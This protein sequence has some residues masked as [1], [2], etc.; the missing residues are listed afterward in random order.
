M[1]ATV[2]LESVIKDE[3][4]CPITFDVMRNPVEAKPCGHI[5][6]LAAIRSSMQLNPVCPLDQKVIVQLNPQVALRNEIHAVIKQYPFLFDNKTPEEMEAE[7]NEAYGNIP[8]NGPGLRPVRNDPIRGLPDV[9]GFE[10]LRQNAANIRVRIFEQPEFGPRGRMIRYRELSGAPIDQ[11]V[12]DHILMN[13]QPLNGQRFALKIA[14]DGS[15]MGIR[16]LPEDRSTML[17]TSLLLALA[18]AA[19]AIMILAFKTQ[20]PEGS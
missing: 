6:E 2:N 8:I 11:F 19:L 1:S 13:R 3:Y 10:R 14:T 7:V 12:R 16:I 5:Y 17:K 18:V 20:N 15:S 9:P 4:Q